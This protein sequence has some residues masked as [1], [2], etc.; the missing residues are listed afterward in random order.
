[1]VAYLFLFFLS[2]CAIA[3]TFAINL[4]IVATNKRYSFRIK[5]LTISKY[6][7]ARHDIIVSVYLDILEL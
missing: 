5:A 7:C 4:F 2:P 6:G 1:M 3:R